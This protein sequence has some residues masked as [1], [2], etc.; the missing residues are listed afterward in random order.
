M[1]NIKIFEN[2]EF[3]SI[4]AVSIDNE[5]WFVGKDVASALGY[6][7]GKSLNNAIANHVH[8]EDKGVTK[9][10]TPGGEQ[11]MVMINE[12]GLYALIFGSRLESS[13]RFKRWV[14]SDVLPSIR[15]TGAYLSSDIDSE[16]LFKM[17]EAMAKKEQEIKLLQAQKAIMEPKADFYDA[18]VESPDAIDMGAVAKVLD[19]GIGRNSIFRIL[20]EAGILQRDN[21]PYQK[22]VDLGYFRCIESKFSTP[23]GGQHI[24]IKTVVHQK[25]L[26]FIR[27]VINERKCKEWPSA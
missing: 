22:Y 5:P 14:T 8:N 19:M 9:M 18:V 23:D 21:L 6:G 2:P 15:K 4:R 12:S 1:E 25:G 11:A 10:M 24:N 26:D 3:G 16:M 17:A 20:R 27:K 13:A 7:Q